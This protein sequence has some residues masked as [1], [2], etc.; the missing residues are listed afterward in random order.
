MFSRFR[1]IVVGIMLY[2]QGLASHTVY[3]D[4]TIE[5]LE[6]RSE[7][8]YQVQKQSERHKVVGPDFAKLV[9]RYPCLRGMVPI[10]R[11]ADIDGH[12]WMCGL[13][14]I[15]SRP[16][17]FSLGSRGNQNFELELLALRPDAR[18]FVFDIFSQLLPPPDQRHPN[19]TYHAVGLG[20]YPNSLPLQHKDVRNAVSRNTPTGIFQSSMVR[21]GRG[22][23]ATSAAAA[24]AV[25][26]LSLRSLAAMLAMC[27]V[28]YIDVLKMDIEG[29]EFAWLKHE[30]EG[31]VPRIGQLLVEVHTKRSSSFFRPVITEDAV[32]F[33]QRLEALGL[34][35]F[36]SEPN[37][38]TP[39]R[40][41]HR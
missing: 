3:N 19:I 18:V 4:A 1:I 36:S 22:F 27:N 37:F 23:D 34:R 28:S 32:W 40:F 11:R 12:K 17:V 7:I 26:S 35:L 5:E 21:V 15:R 16:V 29:F 24:H 39:L 25:P 33:V 30:G 38:A 41:E 2:L 9:S 6:A 31:T 20:G 8:F 10:G 14:A 13:H